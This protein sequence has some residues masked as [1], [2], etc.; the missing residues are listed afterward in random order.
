MPKKNPFVNC[1]SRKR[2]RLFCPSTMV[3]YDNAS[4][5]YNTLWVCKI[6][7]K[8]LLS[9]EAAEGHVINCNTQTKQKKP[10]YKK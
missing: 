7:L 1:K 6:C 8:C 2:K 3:R 4:Y 9:R 5:A 10:N